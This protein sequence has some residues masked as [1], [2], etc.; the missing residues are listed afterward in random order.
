MPGGPKPRPAKL[1]LLVGDMRPSRLPRLGPQPREV[2]PEPPTTLSAEGLAL[3]H[4]LADELAAMGILHSADAL[5]IELLADMGARM[6]RL[7][8]LLDTSGEVIRGR[9]DDRPV[10]NPLWRSY[11]DSCREVARLSAQLGLDPTSRSRIAM[12]EQGDELEEL[13]R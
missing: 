3:W 11:R 9:H 13:L 2:R 10:T 6:R 1:R 4:Q 7:R 12:P 5:V 8:K